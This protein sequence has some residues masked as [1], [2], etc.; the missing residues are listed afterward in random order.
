MAFGDAAAK[1]RELRTDRQLTEA[2]ALLEKV[3][4]Q[5]ELFTVAHSG[6]AARH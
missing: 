2:I 4:T 5:R 3:A 6:L 1:E